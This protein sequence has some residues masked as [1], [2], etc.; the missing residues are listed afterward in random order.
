M[1]IYSIFD[2]LIYDPISHFDTKQ[3]KLFATKKYIIGKKI[4]QVKKILT[5][6]RLFV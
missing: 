4:V 6:L 3:R 2:I 5:K 1:F